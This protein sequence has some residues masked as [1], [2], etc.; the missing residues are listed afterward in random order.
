MMVIAS[1]RRGEFMGWTF[2]DRYLCLL[3][4]QGSRG[5]VAGKERRASDHARSPNQVQ[6]HAA[7]S[8][9]IEANL[10][11]HDEQADPWLPSLVAPER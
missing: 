3:A 8:K 9:V 11:R 7:T 6:C 1:N 5:G 10:L 4:A 2:Q